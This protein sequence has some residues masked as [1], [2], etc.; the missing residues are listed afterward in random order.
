MQSYRDVLVGSKS[1]PNVSSTNKE[2]QPKMPKPI[3]IKSEPMEYL[4]MEG[5][6]VDESIQTNAA[7][8]LED[9]VR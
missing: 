3:L 7:D 2:K 6:T 1:E 5:P 8:V 4:N 9:T